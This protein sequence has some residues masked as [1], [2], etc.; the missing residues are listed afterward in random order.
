MTG[1]SIPEL[2]LGVHPTVRGLAWVLFEGPG[3]PIDWGLVY[4]RREI[5]AACLDRLNHIVDRYRPETLV[6]E[7]FDRRSGRRG[8]RVRALCEAINRLCEGEAV[9]IHSYSAQEIR[10]ALAL[11]IRADRQTIAMRIAEHV[12]VF[13]HRAP[14]PRRAWDPSDRRTA[15]FAAAA[16]VLTHFEARDDS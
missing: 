1:S 3:A 9:A 15:L 7:A 8:P 12:R 4:A 6:M 14:R 10:R 16:V 2:V 5:N 13:V 11:P